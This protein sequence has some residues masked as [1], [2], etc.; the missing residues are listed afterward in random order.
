MLD[1][2]K[3]FFRGDID[4]VYEFSFNFCF[5]MSDIASGVNLLLLYLTE[6]YVTLCTPT[7]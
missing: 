7:Y 3:F 2:E 5:T 4:L 6:R 1:V